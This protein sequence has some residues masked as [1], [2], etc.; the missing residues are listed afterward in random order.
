MDGML[1]P[2]YKSVGRKATP[3]S[4]RR[5]TRSPRSDWHVRLLGRCTGA[6]CI[7]AVLMRRFPPFVIIA[8]VAVLSTGGGIML[9]RSHWP[10]E[11][12][13][14]SGE[15]AT[16]DAAH[17]RGPRNARLTLEEFGDP[18]PRNSTEMSDADD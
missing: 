1:L 12:T 18:C 4:R 17:V 13:S 2:S 16:V 9:Y 11:L 15:R 7:T 5:W 14:V 3:V 10:H 8:M 6:I